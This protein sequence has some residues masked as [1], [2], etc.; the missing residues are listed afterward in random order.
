MTEGLG[1]ILGMPPKSAHCF[2][3]LPQTH[4]TMVMRSTVALSCHLGPIGDH[5]RVSVEVHIDHGDVVTQSTDL[6]SAFIL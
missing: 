5:L 4:D 3:R 2:V 1:L 6:R